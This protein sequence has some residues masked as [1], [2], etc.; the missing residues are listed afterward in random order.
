MTLNFVFF[1]SISI[2]IFCQS[3]I[4][5]IGLRKLLLF[6]CSICLSLMTF[7]EAFSF[8]FLATEA[9]LEN[10]GYLL[11][12]L[13]FPL[14]IFVVPETYPQLIAVSNITSSEIVVRTGDSVFAD[15]NGI[16]LYYN[17][18]VTDVEPGFTKYYTAD[19]L[20]S[21]CTSQNS[22]CSG[23]DTCSFVTRASM[24]ASW[25]DLEKQHACVGNYSEMPKSAFIISYTVS[26]LRYWTH[27][28][29]QS[30]LCNSKGCGEFTASVAVRTDE[31]FPTCAPNATSMHNTSS[32]SMTVEWERTPIA[33]THGVLLYFNVF[34]S[35]ESAIKGNECFNDTSC[36]PEHSPEDIQT[37]FY[38]TNVTD[39]HISFSGLKKYRRY[40]AFLQAVTKKG[41]GPASQPF[42]NITAEDGMS[43]FA[44]CFGLV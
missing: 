1:P 22:N 16:I 9:K 41:A 11:H 4:A 37:R 12:N 25:G 44:L 23:S 8:N 6:P 24:T 7:E 26:N 31:H 30:S 42:C 28:S 36:W 17:I 18:S 34:F 33:C 19:I 2:S 3:T 35:L 40:C 14:I 27:Y 43:L 38:V 10:S 32:T 20:F 5:T 39:Q 15:E 21:N 29:V 13:T